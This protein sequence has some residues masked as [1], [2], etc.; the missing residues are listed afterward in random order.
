MV[1]YLKTPKYC[2]QDISTQSISPVKT[3]S[4]IVIVTPLKTKN[5]IAYATTPQ[6]GGNREAS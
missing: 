2:K 4:I 1:K 3:Y 5:S 6:P